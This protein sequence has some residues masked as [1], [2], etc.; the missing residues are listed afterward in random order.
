[1]VSPDYG[2]CR[3]SVV[4]VRAK[5]EDASEL[6][7]QLLFG[8]HYTV[9][10]SSDDRKW[11]YIQNAFDNYEGWIDIK[12]HHSIT[13]DYFEQLDNTEYK[14]CTDHTARILY[15]KNVVHVT[16]GAILPL[17]SNP[18]FVTEEQLAFNGEAKSLF[19]RWTI[20]QLLTVA[21]KYLNAP[22][23]WGGKTP[24]GIDCS[25]LTQQVFRVSG[26]HLKR[27]SSQQICQG[28]EVTFEEK[29]PGDLAFFKNDNGM[30]NHVGIVLPDDSIIHASG[31][32]RIDGLDSEGILDEVSNKHTHKLFKIK[33]IVN[34]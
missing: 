10:N 28:K 32:V 34:S 13:F 24:F 11:I 27:D 29:L 3:L 17:L 2:I 8:E 15:N 26:Y 18:L 12:Q 20:E 23:L 21:K 30:M 22:Y 31:R 16:I 19:Q 1:M 9:L 4:P 5:G 7:S 33:R 14:I 25:G 6:I